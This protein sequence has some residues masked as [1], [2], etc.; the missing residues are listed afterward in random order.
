M[1]YIF[2]FAIVILVAGFTYSNMGN[3]LSNEHE[4][5]YI[6]E[7]KSDMY[8]NIKGTI[9]VPQSIINKPGKATATVTYDKS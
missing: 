4:P 9:K 6:G 3:T 1:N 8:G 5:Y 7:W 2:A